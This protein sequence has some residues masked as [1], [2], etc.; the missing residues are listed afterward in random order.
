MAGCMNRLETNPANHELIAMF[1]KMGVGSP[2]RPPVGPSGPAHRGE[3]KVNVTIFGELLRSADEVCM[4]MRL[5][6]CADA[7]S[8]FASKFSI[9]IDV[10]FRIDDQSLFRLLTAQEVGVLRQLRIEDLSEEHEENIAQMNSA[11]GIN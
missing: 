8:I 5:C 3:I 7:Q 4:D 9:S 1:K 11:M 2:R 10:A 6:D